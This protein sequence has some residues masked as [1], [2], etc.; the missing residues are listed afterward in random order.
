MQELPVFGCTLDAAAMAA[1][2]D[3]Y[4]RLAA[5][6]AGTRREPQRLH[7]R[8]DAGVDRDLLAETLAIE[9]ECCTF[10]GVALDGDTAELT[11]PAAEM[12]PALDALAY[13]LG[14]G[15]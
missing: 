8:F 9:A 5:H 1:Q 10:F 12:D 7:V 13:A 15:Q 11:V 6:V 14:T 4:A 2:R 3:R